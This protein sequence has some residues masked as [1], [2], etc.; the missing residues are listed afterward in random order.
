[1]INTRRIWKYQ[2]GS[3][4][5][6]MHEERT[7]K[8][9]TTSGTYPWSVV[10]QIFYNGQPKVVCCFWKKHFQLAGMVT[11]TSLICTEDVYFQTLDLY[12]TDIPYD[13]L[14]FTY[15]I[16][17]QGIKWCGINFKLLRLTRKNEDGQMWTFSYIF[18][19]LRKF[20]EIQNF[21]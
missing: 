11:L 6:Y 4:N 16:T 1:M 2:R 10:T 20:T 21:P 18:T 19:I 13:T 12:E 17:K 14:P 15:Y 9:Y 7:G 5:P 8:C 3:Q